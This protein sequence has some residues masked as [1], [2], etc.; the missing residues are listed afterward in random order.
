MPSLFSRLKP[1][2]GRCP[3]WLCGRRPRRLRLPPPP[4]PEGLPGPAFIV[5]SSCCV[6]VAEFYRFPG[7]P[8]CRWP[9]F[10][11]RLRPLHKIGT[12]QLR[13]TTGHTM[14]RTPTLQRNCY[15]RMKSIFLTQY[16]P[17]YRIRQAPPRIGWRGRPA[18]ERGLNEN[19]FMVLALAQPRK[20]HP[21]H[22]LH[23]R[24]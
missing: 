9:L 8:P 19:N 5:L 23:R 4:P 13:A 7:F 6:L 11:A 20:A 15:S 10:Q 22:L 14:V 1:G 21:T 16:F 3:R 2:P 24:S 12:T 17:F 18:R